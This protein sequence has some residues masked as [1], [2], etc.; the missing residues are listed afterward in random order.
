MVIM[1]DVRHGKYD[2]SLEISDSKSI[3]REL[4][5]VYDRTVKNERD[6]EYSDGTS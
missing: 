3:K 5:N 2:I 4:Q 6:Q 1:S